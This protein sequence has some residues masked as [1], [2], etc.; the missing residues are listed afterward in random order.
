MSKFIAILFAV[1]LSGCA[2][3]A[4]V[5]G[6]N[7]V[8][9]KSSAGFG[10]KFFGDSHLGSDALIDAFRH[11]FFVQNSVGFVPA[12]MPKYHKSENIEFKQ[13]GFNVISSRTEQ[14]PDFPL[15]GVIATGKKGA[16]VRLELKQ[17]SGDF[18]V[19][20]L[21]KSDQSGEIFR[22]RDASGLSAY[23]SQ[24]VPQKWEY[25]KLRLR[26]PIEI[27]SLRDGAELGGYK[28]Y[29]KNARFADSCA[30]NGAFSNL[31][32]KWGADAFG[33]DFSGLRYNLVVIAYGTNDAMDPKFDEQKFY[34]SVR[35]LLRSVR[36]AAP[37]AK[38]LLVAPPRSPKVPNASRAA[39]VLAHLARDEGA[40][41]YDI[42]GLMDE[43]GG[44]RGWRERGLIR[45]DEIH[46]QKEGYEKIG[47]ALAT[48]LRG[49]L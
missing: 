3:N 2:A 35:G 30:S 31:Y 42:A 4:G 19:E 41:F 45:P 33:R 48:K 22:V 17:L 36:S 7:S 5:R 6:I 9:A 43:D 28:I 32:E 29:R 25:S 13:S 39:E 38:I 27:R 40:M 18:Y 49:R 46:L 12:M 26:F 44:W 15:C 47:A 1:L 37:G 24:E 20:I 14:D 16:N 23:I 10:V 11:G 21:H 34:Q 8:N